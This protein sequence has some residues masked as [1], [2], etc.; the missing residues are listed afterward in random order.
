VKKVRELKAKHPDTYQ[1]KPPTKRLAAI[2]KLAF[3]VIPQ[4]P[5]SEKFR[6]G[7]T[8]G[9]QYRH[10]R[11]AKFF[12]QYRLF[13]R[14][15]ESSRIIILGWVN[16]ENEKRAYGS[17]SDAYATFRKRLQAGDP[18]ADWT[19]LMKEASALVSE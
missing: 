13:F 18:P 15:N 6:Q 16:N 4:D 10:W 19:D 7:N 11:R 12:Q 1:E 8:L 17:K 9:P 5:A 2:N 3:D 14:Y